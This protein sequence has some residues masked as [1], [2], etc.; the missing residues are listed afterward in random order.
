MGQRPTGPT[1]RSTAATACWAATTRPPAASLRGQQW[2]FDRFQADYNI[3]R[4]HEA[5]DD[6]SPASPWTPSPRPYPTRLEPPHYPG[7][8]E[9][10]LVSNAGHFR[11]G[12][13]QH[14][15]S[16]ALRGDHVGL[17]PIDDGLWNILYY[18]TLLGR[19]SERTG[20]ISGASFRSDEC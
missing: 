13:Q 19:L 6:E 2:K 5:L 14:F 4:P 20:K 10:R 3:D 15:I 1:W 12:S 17:E 18:N 8:F 7:H 11:M 16:H 9:L